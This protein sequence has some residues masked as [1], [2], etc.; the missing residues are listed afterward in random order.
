VWEGGVF[1][2]YNVYLRNNKL[3]FQWTDAPII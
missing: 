2:W 1:V 3:Q